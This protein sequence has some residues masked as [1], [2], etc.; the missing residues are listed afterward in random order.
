M[1]KVSL[2]GQA[3]KIIVW[4]RMN[5]YLYMHSLSNQNIKKHY[6]VKKLFS[7]TV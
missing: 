5:T 3:I 1:P 4:V 6:F 2:K 7:V